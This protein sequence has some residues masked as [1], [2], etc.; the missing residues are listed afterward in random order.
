MQTSSDGRH[1]IATDSIAL[2]PLKTPKMFGKQAILKICGSLPYEMQAMGFICSDG[3]MGMD[4]SG[5][6]LASLKIWLSGAT[7]DAKRKNG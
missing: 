1:I 2:E 5:Y 4:N 3:G 6:G 7:V